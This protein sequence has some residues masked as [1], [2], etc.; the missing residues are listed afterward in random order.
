MSNI[1]AFKAA[2]LPAVDMNRFK[3]AI[4]EGSAAAKAIASTSGLF[5]RMQKDGIWVYGPDNVE[6]QEKSLWAINPYSISLGFAAWGEEGTKDEGTLLGERMA[7][8]TESAF[9]LSMLPNVGAAWAP[10]VQFDLMCLNGDDVGT[11]VRYKATSVGGRRA[12]SGM[13]DQVKKHANEDGLIVPVVDLLT[14]S[15]INKKYGKTYVPVFEVVEWKAPDDTV[16]GTPAEGEEAETTKADASTDNQ[17]RAEK[18]AATAAGANGTSTGGR[19]RRGPVTDV[20]EPEQKAAETSKPAA[21]PV[22]RGAV[23]RRRRAA[24]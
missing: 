16:L 2:G 21:Q 4:A 13:L 10:Q 11:A 3:Q 9:S 8:I 18:P 15:Y 5:L 1:T 23:V 17:Q 22:D 12:F 7:L 6:V 20:K 24:V 14:D 19:R